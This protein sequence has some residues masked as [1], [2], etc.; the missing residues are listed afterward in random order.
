MNPSLKTAWHFQNILYVSTSVQIWKEGH[1]IKPS[2]NIFRKLCMY[3]L[4]CIV[5]HGM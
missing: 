1:L 2:A 4:P 5:L 3:V